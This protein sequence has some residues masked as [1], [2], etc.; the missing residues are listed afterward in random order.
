MVSNT[1]A[2][3]IQQLAAPHF[4]SNFALEER[5]A[6]ATISYLCTACTTVGTRLVIPDQVV[7]DCVSNSSRLTCN[8][9]TVTD[10]TGLRAIRIVYV[11]G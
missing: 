2:T 3:V 5:N 9:C 6:T 11:Q 10:G 4:R 1:A 7:T 8:S